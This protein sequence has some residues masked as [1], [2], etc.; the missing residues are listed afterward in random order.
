MRASY[1][2]GFV[3]TFLH[4]HHHD[5]LVSLLYVKTRRLQEVTW[6]PLEPSERN[7]QI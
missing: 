6:T 1:Y 4:P 2:H 3:A 5:L 7:T